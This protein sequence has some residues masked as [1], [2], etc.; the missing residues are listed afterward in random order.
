MLPSSPWLPQ[1]R[2][3]RCVCM[4][5]TFTRLLPLARDGGWDLAELQAATGCGEQCGMCRPYLRAMLACGT[6]IFHSVLEDVSD[7]DEAAA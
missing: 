6:T 4:R 5:A 1:L 7:S 2:I 3:D